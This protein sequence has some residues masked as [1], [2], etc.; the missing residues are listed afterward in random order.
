MPKSLAIVI[1]VLIHVALF[2]WLNQS[3]WLADLFVP[4]E[5]AKL[6]IQ[7][8][9]AQIED[10]AQAEHQA[11][12]EQGQ[13]K[14]VKSAQT[15]TLPASTEKHVEQSDMGDLQ[16]FLEQSPFKEIYPWQP[17]SA[18][19]SFSYSDQAN[20]T[21]K[22]QTQ[23]IDTSKLL[24]I[25]GLTIADSEDPATNA[26]FSPEL[27][28]QI[29]KAQSDHQEYLKNQEK[30]HNYPITEDADGT[31]YV[32]IEGVCWKIPNDP[33]KEEWAIVLSGCGGQTKTFHFE[34]NI[35]PDLLGPDSPLLFP[36]E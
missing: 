1:A 3:Q 14:E 12:T 19:P 20:L 23:T 22:E 24:D 29:K 13:T 28:K 36:T 16:P 30:E 10:V 21:A 18:P 4:Y 31:R 7:I 35:A 17:T 2:F 27:K 33:T 9:P 11:A 6:E 34:L 26:I 25:G 5:P 15:D 8:Q 32:N